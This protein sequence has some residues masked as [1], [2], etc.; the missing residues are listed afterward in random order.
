MIS[1]LASL[2]AFL[3]MASAQTRFTHT[4]RDVVKPDKARFFDHF[5]THYVHNSLLEALA[6][7]KAIW[8]MVATNLVLCEISSKL[9][10]DLC[11]QFAA[12][13]I[14]SDQKINGFQ[15]FPLR[16]DYLLTSVAALKS[17]V[18]GSLLSLSEPG[19]EKAKEFLV[20]LGLAEARW[21]RN[22]T[23][24]PSD[25][26][27]VLK[28]GED[29]ITEISQVASLR[30]YLSF[31]RSLRNWL[32][33]P[34]KAEI[35]RLRIPITKLVY[36]MGCGYSRHHASIRCYSENGL[37]PL[38]PLFGEDRINSASYAHVDPRARW[39]I[40]SLPDS[41]VLCLSRQE[42]PSRYHCIGKD[43][44]PEALLAK[45]FHCYGQGPIP[46]IKNEFELDPNTA[47][48]VHSKVELICTNRNI[49]RVMLFDKN[50]EFFKVIDPEPSELLRRNEEIKKM[51]AQPISIPNGV[52]AY[53]IGDGICYFQTH[54][55]ELVC[56]DPAGKS[57]DLK[58]IPTKNLSGLYASDTTLC[59]SDRSGQYSCRDMKS[60]ATYSLRPGQL[61]FSGVPYS[62]QNR[63]W[64][65]EI[66]YPE[67]IEPISKVATIKTSSISYSGSWPI[68]QVRLPRLEVSEEPTLCH[69]EKGVVTC[70]EGEE[71]KIRV[72]LFSSL[73]SVS[74]LMQNG[75][76]ICALTEKEIICAK[77]NEKFF[78]LPSDPVQTRRPLP[79][80]FKHQPVTLMLDRHLCATSK[81]GFWCAGISN[82][83]DD[84]VYHNGADEFIGFAGGS[85]FCFNTKNTFQ[86]WPTKTSAGQ[87]KHFYLTKQ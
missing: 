73:R 21:K 22:N 16:N 86:C 60:G 4:P 41:E 5:Q 67:S 33:N 20:S 49:R 52:E 6:E 7:E 51:L 34:G 24:V 75:D 29:F 48:R 57:I 68:F 9:A 18:T 26:I 40:H 47:L 31:F 17:I 30:P 74:S 69:L 62:I 2:M 45:H 10:K 87:S 66:S 43:L 25:L 59:V 53:K 39:D 35:W 28:F 37:G 76:S 32:E 3:Q 70:R 64:K 44:H 82:S 50:G 63:D 38:V 46:I 12:S 42:N 72:H 65:I 13:P 85:E 54:Q 1:L 58:Q 83:E 71:K 61:R 84:F 14:L 55:R 56:R 78:S 81:G 27:D 8:H 77:W 36:G 19:R 11:D 79:D 15:G 80:Y 23:V